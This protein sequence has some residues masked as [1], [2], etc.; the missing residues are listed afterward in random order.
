M[1]PT[2]R[3][4]KMG[5]F[6]TGSVD[7]PFAGN[8]SPDDAKVAAIAKGKTEVL[9]KAGTFLESLTVVENFALM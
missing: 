3:S 1:S 4:A 7:Q 6:E 5:R 8:Q 2:L 9:E